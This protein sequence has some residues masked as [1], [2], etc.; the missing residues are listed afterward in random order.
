MPSTIPH[1][2]PLP[3]QPR[4][5]WKNVSKALLSGWLAV[6]T[7]MTSHVATAAEPTG[8]S[9]AFTSQDPAVLEAHKLMGAGDFRSAEQVL[10]AADPKADTAALR[11]RSELIE[12]MQRVRH[13]YSLDAAGLLAKVKLQIPDA[14]G[15]DV[16][17]WTHE[18]TARYRVID[19]TKFYFRR[20]P[21]NVFLFSKE[22]IERRAQAGR[23]PAKSDWL[24][25]DHLAE[26]V[27]AAEQSTSAEVLPVKHRFTHTITIRGNH[28]QIK[29]G[30]I[31][32]VWMPFAQEYR[33]QRDVKLIS[34]SPEP[35]VIAPTGSEGDPVSGGAQRTVYFEQVVED[36]SKPLVFQEVLEFTSSAYYPKLDAAQ[37]EP[38]PSHWHDAYLNERPPHIVFA[39][40]IRSE[41][42]SI[43]G[44]ETNPLL[45]AQK[46][47]RWVSLNVPWN[48][49]DEYCIIP[50]LAVKGF[51][52]RCGDCGVQNTL[53]ITM[54][55][56]AGI[57]ARWQSGFQTKPSRRWGL[58]DWAEIYI[59]PWGWLPADA[60]YGIQPSDDPRVAD[61]YL[62][63][64]DSYRLIVNLD[65]GREL[66]PPKQS[67]RSEPADFQ[68]G[69]V[70][71][72]GQNLYFNEWE[73]KTEI[74]YD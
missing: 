14:S 57:P 32:R 19:G 18:T 46:I 15:E 68:R 52:A 11:A 21:Q 71:I 74:E 73:S 37:V 66:F 13:E 34:A 47:F 9:A 62:G 5:I 72:D 51:D 45:K 50:S 27:A 22:A 69:E 38:L 41:V 25:I 8:A 60:S 30:S 48:A 39:P 23:A 54:C 36:P 61:F 3:T 64:Q 6:A 40:Q 12:I 56:I 17:R 20:E 63:H 55:R 7:V 28:P 53:F 65:W 44:A 49:E 43:I 4:P 24:L 35:K 58:H 70:E 1:R 16:E 26:V 31:V 33:Q 2:L 10:S 42:A 29:T 59:A 67:L